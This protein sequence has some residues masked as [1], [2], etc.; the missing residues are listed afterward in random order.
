MREDQG[1]ILRMTINTDQGDQYLDWEQSIL[2]K[3][4][5]MNRRIEGAPGGIYGM[6]ETDKKRRK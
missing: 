3:M 6:R 4:T 5:A 2:Q 1:L